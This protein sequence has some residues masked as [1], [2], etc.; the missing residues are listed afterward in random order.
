[1]P[2]ASNL[3]LLTSELETMPFLA[4]VFY[5]GNIALTPGH[6]CDCDPREMLLF[7]VVGNE[8]LKDTVRCAIY[9]SSLNCKYRAW[10]TERNPALSTMF[11]L[12][13]Y[14]IVAVVTPG[15]VVDNY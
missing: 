2:A 6:N 4:A 8:D 12:G 11:E 14:V 15:S 10:R 13:N 5:R 9:Q 1:M 3:R 7:V